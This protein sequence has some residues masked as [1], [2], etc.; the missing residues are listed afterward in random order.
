MVH[1]E[2]E[3]RIWA[4]VLKEHKIKQDVVLAFEQARPSDISGWSPVLQAL[5]KP[6][7]LAQPVM[8]R[9]HVNELD[10]FGRTV[11][12]PSDFVESVEFDKFEL[13]LFPEKKKNDP[14][15]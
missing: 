1:L 12:L 13:E 11:F 7:D 5:C 4:K 6:L 10:R 2:R 14:V 9:K 15:A 8:L 3:V